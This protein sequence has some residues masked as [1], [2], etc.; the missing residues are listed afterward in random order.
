MAR[1]LC[2]GP[3]C[4]GDQQPL[5]GGRQQVLQRKGIHVMDGQSNKLEGKD[6]M[7]SSSSAD[8]TCVTLSQ[9]LTLFGPQEVL[10]L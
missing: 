5:S 10:D 2:C 6:T 7:A 3:D 8:D 4:P 1:Q 9:S